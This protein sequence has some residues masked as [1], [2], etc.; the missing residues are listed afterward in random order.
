MEYR[1]IT[2]I[3]RLELVELLEDK[4]KAIG[5]HGMS[6]TKVE[7]FGEYADLYSTSWHSSHMRV[8]IFADSS[9]TDDIVTAIMEVAHTGVVGDGIVAVLP[10]EKLFNIRTFAGKTDDA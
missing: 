8:E 2:A 6:V 5:V 7:G 3:V 1:K 4:L 10:V 9:T